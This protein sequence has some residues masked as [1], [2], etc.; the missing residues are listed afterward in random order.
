MMKREVVVGFVWNSLNLL[1]SKGASLLFVLFLARLLSPETFGLIAMIAICFELG[2]VFVRS[3]LQQAI[4]RSKEIRPIDL[5]SAFYANIALSLLAYLLLFTVAPHIAGF[6]ERPELKGLIEVAGLV[7]CINSL[8]IVQ[9]AI[10]S[11]AMNFKALMF[12]NSTSTVVGGVGALVLAYAAYGVWSLVAQMLVMSIVST[13]ILWKLSEWRPTASFSLDSVKTLMR[14]GDKLLVEGIL[15]VI[16]RNSYIVVIGSVFS[17]EVAGLYFF[18]RRLQQ[19]IS[20]QLTGAVQQTTYPFLSTLQDDNEELK[21][22]YRQIGQILMFATGAVMV[23]VATVAESLFSLFL[24][25]RW[26]DAAMYLQLLCIL[27]LMYP[28]HAMNINILSV[29]GRTDLILSI[30]MLKKAVT[31]AILFLS[32]P[33]G[34]LG[35]IVGQIIGSLLCLVPNTYYSVKLINYGVKEQLVDVLKPT[36]AAAI[37]YVCVAVVQK[38]TDQNDFIELFV[39]MF[40]VFVCYMVTNLVFKTD[41]LLLLW[42]QVRQRNWLVKL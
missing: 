14:F 12:A 9:M 3:G 29:K 40:A 26:Q 18:S 8:K 5:D 27:G 4:I 17:A 13:A 35:I 1:V 22:R 37:T 38:L 41:G 7:V 19:V 31:L 28:L 33:F 23:T 36:I 20:Q 6:Y 39:T 25:P 10:L 16:S 34:V 2:N 11:R 42:K 32:I 30:G 21:N 24:D 15:L